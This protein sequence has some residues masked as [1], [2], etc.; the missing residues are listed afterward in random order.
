MMTT[1]EMD[2]STSLWVWMNCPSS[3]ALAPSDTN[4]VE[5]PRTKNSEAMTTLR[6]TRLPVCPS[7][8]IWSSVVP[9]R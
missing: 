5:K 2:A 3:E 1:P 9:P 8:V 6:Q 7:E 4:T